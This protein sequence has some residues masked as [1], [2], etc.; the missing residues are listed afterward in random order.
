MMVYH[1]VIS[2]IR[3]QLFY[4]LLAH[5]NVFRVLLYFRL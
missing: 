3:T 2:Y 5:M 1:E 4:P